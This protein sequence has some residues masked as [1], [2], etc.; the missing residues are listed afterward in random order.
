VRSL[1]LEDA[2]QASRPAS[3]VVH[4]PDPGLARG[5]WEAPASGLYLAMA[6]VLVGAALYLAVRLGLRRRA[7]RPAVVKR[8]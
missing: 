3:E 5:L 4:R 2:Q 1:L 7:H 6:A 8:P